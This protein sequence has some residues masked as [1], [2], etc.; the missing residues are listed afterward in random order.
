[1]DKRSYQKQNF[2][3]VSEQT[4]SF[5]TPQQTTVQQQAILLFSSLTFADLNEEK[6]TVCTKFMNLIKGDF[7][8]N[9]I[10]VVV[11][12]LNPQICFITKK[13]PQWKPK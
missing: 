3:L 2:K 13:V 9:A 5:F 10:R 4:Y 12:Y 7:D 6:S 8:G 11:Y 1:L